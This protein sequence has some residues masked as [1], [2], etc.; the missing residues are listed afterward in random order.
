MIALTLTV[1][2]KTV[3][4]LTRTLYNLPLSGFCIVKVFFSIRPL[5][6]SVS[7]ALPHYLADHI[8]SHRNISVWREEYI[9]P[10]H[11][12]GEENRTTHTRMHAHKVQSN[13]Y[14]WPEKWSR[15]NFWGCDSECERRE[16][17]CASIVSVAVSINVCVNTK[18][19]RWLFR[20]MFD[21]RAEG[22]RHGQGHKGETRHIDLK[23]FSPYITVRRTL[24]SPLEREQGVI[25]T[26]RGQPL[27]SDFQKWIHSWI[28]L[29]E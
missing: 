28:W 21:A 3:T 24:Q 27:K 18:G 2:Q 11:G 25:I 13:T 9:A 6:S 4:S 22:E 12:G 29:L 1:A 23:E 7:V 5:L 10:A 26:N 20:C 14:I 17:E 15:Q 19:A 8:H 16:C